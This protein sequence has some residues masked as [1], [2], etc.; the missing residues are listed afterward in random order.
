MTLNKIETLF[1]QD[2]ENKIAQGTA[3]GGEKIITGIFPAENGY[4]P[5][6][7]LQG[8]PGRRFLR[9]NANAYLGLGNHPDVVAAETE[10][11]EKFG[12]G[13]G[14]VRFISGTYR[15]HIELEA[16][17]AAFHGR[18]AAMLFSAA[19]ATMI[20]VLPALIDE[21]T[22]VVSDALNHNCII[23]AIRLSKPAQKAVYPHAD[24]AALE[25]IL[26]TAENS[27]KRVIVVS[28]GIFS[29]RG[30]AAP[31]AA[32]VECCKRYERF[33]EQGIITVVDDS[34]GAFAF[35]ASGR[36]TEENEGARAD[37]LVATLGKALGV[38]GGYAVSSRTVIDY[39]KETAA[40]YIY[41]N[42]ITPAEAA[43]A[44]CALRIADGPTGRELLRR[45]RALTDRLRNGLLRLGLDTLPGE[46][47]I[48]PL[49]I[50]DTDK[51]SALVRHL[52]DHD[53]LATGLNYPVVAKGEQEIRLQVSAVHTE[54]DIDQVVE[55]LRRFRA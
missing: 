39:L 19:Y 1:E 36:G 2:I 14:A 7:A 21:H 41:S 31:L 24:V 12:T 26:S 42:P 38:N 30:D 48:V 29:M 9:M 53:I 35:G 23:N 32:I 25:H 10:A 3:K 49:M 47:P 17:L 8:Y 37:I 54:Q 15:T 45:L 55:V 50:R 43:A 16:Q 6:L 27:I 44:G 33:F 4:G 46:H 20:G 52:F 13:P 22:L 40:S 11:A 34:H 5:R 28:D 51:T 18:E